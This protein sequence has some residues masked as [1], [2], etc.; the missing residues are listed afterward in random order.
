MAHYG[1]VIAILLLTAVTLT[2]LALASK[3]AG[4]VKRFREER[5]VHFTGRRQ[6]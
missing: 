6:R 5:H 1:V 3:A 4:S 2:A